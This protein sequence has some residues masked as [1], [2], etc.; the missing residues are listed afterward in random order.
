MLLIADS[1]STKTDWRL[2][3]NAGN[4]FCSIQSKGLNPY[5]WT[6]K[7]IASI[8][9]QEVFPKVN[10]VG[11]IIFYGSGCG[12]PTKAQQ[13]LNALFRVFPHSSPE[14]YGDMLGAARSVL[15]DHS[16]IACILGTGANS[17]VYNGE[18]MI[19]NVPSLG[20][21]LADYGSGAVL[22]KDMISLILREK[23]V[24]E[25]RMEFGRLYKLDQ[26]QILDHLYNQ[27]GT[28]TFLASFSPFLL[29]YKDQPPFREM[30]LNNFAQFFDYYVK[31]YPAYQPGMTVGFVGSIAYYFS[32]LL[33][34][35]AS[36]SGI[37]IGNIVQNP[38][39]GL[40]NYHCPQASHES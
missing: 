28:N 23:V 11:K 34:T 14:V 12:S 36:D 1:G 27:P 5:F 24:E 8:I 37:L 20:F 25:I 4:I 39:Q 9:L 38:M 16:G 22:G 21:I 35:S 2:V 19:D 3:D 33:K 7:E 13:V 30:I 31:Q 29:K 40:I 32:D 26:R 6:E 18:K 15:Q 10:K 17:C